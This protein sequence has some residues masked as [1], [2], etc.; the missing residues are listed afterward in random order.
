[1]LFGQRLET[2]RF[3]MLE[4]RFHDLLGLYPDLKFRHARRYA[5]VGKMVQDA[6]KAYA[7]DVRNSAFPTDANS[8]SM[9]PEEEAQLQ[10]L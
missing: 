6:I 8:F 9:A 3:V 7:D 1:M 2:A 4:Y 5:E 10:E